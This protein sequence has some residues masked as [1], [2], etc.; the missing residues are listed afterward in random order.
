MAKKIYY[1]EKGFPGGTPR[2]TDHNQGQPQQQTYYGSYPV[3]GSN[4]IY[5]KTSTP[6]YTGTKTANVTFG[7]GTDYG[8]NVTTETFGNGG[9]LY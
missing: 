1:G 2:V 7:D 9:A 3:I 8:Y 4:V 6:D 5:E